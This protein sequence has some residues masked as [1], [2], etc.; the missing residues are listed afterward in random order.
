MCVMLRECVCHV[1]GVCV[2]VCVMVRVR[3]SV[4][5]GAPAEVCHVEGVCV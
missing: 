5:Q 4:C 3:V 2:C 1:K